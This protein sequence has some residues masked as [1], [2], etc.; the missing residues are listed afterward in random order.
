VLALREAM[1]RRASPSLSEVSRVERDL[2]LGGLEAFAEAAKRDEEAWSSG[3]Y[4]SVEEAVAEFH[5]L[6]ERAELAGKLPYLRERAVRWGLEPV[7]TPEGAMRLGAEVVA[8]VNLG[9]AARA[10]R[11]VVTGE[12]T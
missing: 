6:C 5:A 11:I 12:L 7:S 2:V 3:D 9:H 8:A 1:M 4:A 10:E